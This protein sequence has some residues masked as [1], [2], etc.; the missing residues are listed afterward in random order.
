MFENKKKLQKIKTGKM[1]ID[2]EQCKKS[3]ILEYVKYEYII[4]AI[5]SSY[6]LI[7]IINV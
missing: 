1:K 7:G 3:E 4:Y 5:N 2:N 6:L